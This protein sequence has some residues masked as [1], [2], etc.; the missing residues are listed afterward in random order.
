MQQRADRRERN[1]R[2]ARCS[3]ARK[4]L[5]IDTLQTCIKSLQAEN[6]TMK[7]H[8]TGRFGDDGFAN[9]MTTH[10]STMDAQLAKDSRFDLIAPGAADAVSECASHRSQS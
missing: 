9:L 8:I 1:R 3:R 4:K 5:L 10:G 6:R 7:E 2:H